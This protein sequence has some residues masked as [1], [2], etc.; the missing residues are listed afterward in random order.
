MPANIAHFGGGYVACT[1]AGQS[2]QG[3][4]NGIGILLSIAAAVMIHER[5][6]R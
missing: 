5:F 4:D 3:R 2:R 6:D 1:T